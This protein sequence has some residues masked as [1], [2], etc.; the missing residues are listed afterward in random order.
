MSDVAIYLVQADAQAVLRE[1]ARF[2]SRSPN[3]TVGH[4]SR[5]PPAP[6]TPQ[7]KLLTFDASFE[8]RIVPVVGKFDTFDDATAA[9]AATG[10]APG[11]SGSEGMASAAQAEAAVQSPH[12]GRPG[13]GR[14]T[15][16]QVYSMAGVWGTA[17]LVYH[18]RAAQARERT[19]TLPVA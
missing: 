2:R 10:A 9:Y 3:F 4:A 19:P 15:L 14:W 7:A 13:P 11:A 1:N 6:T 18:G 12:P 17:W 16:V 8:S 5:C